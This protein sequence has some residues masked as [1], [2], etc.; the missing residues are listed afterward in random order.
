MR[1]IFVTAGDTTRPTGGYRYNA[2]VLGVLRG[3]GHEVEEAATPDAGLAAQQAAAHELGSRVLSSSADALLIDALARGACAPWLDTARAQRAVVALVHEPAII[4]ESAAQ[5]ADAGRA[6][7]I[8]GPILRA[9]RLIVP[10]DEGRVV[11]GAGGVPAERIIVAL[12]G[13]DRPADAPNVARR[14]GGTVR[15]LCAAQWIPRKGILTLVEAWRRLGPAN[16]TL[17]LAGETDIDPPYAGLVRAALAEL[18]SVTV[19]GALDQ[20]ALT[21]AYASADLFVLPSRSEGY[22]MVYA[23][24]LAHGLPIVACDVGPVPEVVGE[25]GLL[26]APD[27]PSALAGALGLLIGDA[28]LRARLA[29]A[30]HERART[31]PAWEDTAAAVLRALNEAVADHAVGVRARRS[32]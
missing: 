11:L 29:S 31:L 3:L 30:A 12:P 10:S 24:A 17:T 21:R 1:I 25:A 4:A 14:R 18:T 9:N 5:A 6:A 28:A 15:A 7:A 22:G 19:A 23:E 32:S 2:R 20:A 13:C 16:A 27:D 26:V 8:D